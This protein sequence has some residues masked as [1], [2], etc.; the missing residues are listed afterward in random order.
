MPESLSS[1][2]SSSEASDD[3]DAVLSATSDS[4]MIVPGDSDTE[5]PY[6]HAPRK[7]RLFERSSERRIIERLPIKLADGRLLKTGVKDLAPSDHI[8]EEDIEQEESQDKTE[9][10]AE[11]I[12]TGAR[13]GRPAVLDIVNQTSKRHRI[14]HAKEQIAGICQEIVADPENSVRHREAYFVTLSYKLTS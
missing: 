9:C 5:M 1:F 7:S 6:E 10:K 14:E 11:D 12:S 2:E 3:A 13:F 8:A 4:H